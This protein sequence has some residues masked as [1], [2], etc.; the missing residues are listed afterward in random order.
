MIESQEILLKESMLKILPPSFAC[1]QWL[2]YKLN[3]AM[4][5]HCALL[6]V[7]GARSFLISG[8]IPI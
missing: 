2:R 7:D 5:A 6:V 1:V 8:I 4:G 3:S